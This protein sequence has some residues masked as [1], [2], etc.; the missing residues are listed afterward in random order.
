MSGV[1]HME[2]GPIGK[3]LLLFALPVLISQVL[4]ELYNI[5]DCAI[6]GHFAGGLCLAA[7][8]IAGLLLSVF[9]NFFIGFSSGVSVV[10]GRLF[11]EYDYSSLKK[12]MNSVM[13]LTLLTG[14]IVT[15]LTSAF[16]E[17]LLMLLNCPAEVFAAASLYLHICA[18]GLCA[19][20][21][22]N[23]GTAILRSLADTRAPLLCFFTSCISNLALDILFVV[24]FDM[25]IAGA[26]AATLISQWILAILIFV[27]LKSLG[28]EC[29]LELKGDHL[30]LK[31]L[32]DILKIG[33]PA[34]MQALFM[35]MS[36]LILQTNINTFGPAAVAGMTCYSKLEGCLYLPAFSYGIAL[37]GFVGQN[38][39]A[40]RTDRIQ[41]AVRISNRLMWAVILPLSLLMVFASPLLLKIFTND[42]D[43]L[44]NAHEALAWNSP[45][46]VIYAMN[47]V[48]LGALKGSGR[49][50]YP[51]IC[52]L[53]CYSIFRVLWCNMLI[54]FFNTM[55]VV[56]LCYDIS[57]FLMFFMLLP[58][59]KST[60]G[61]KGK[62]QPVYPTA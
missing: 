40:G 38:Y 20:L 10:T 55:T 7:T 59:Y 25:G 52:T 12:T 27:R 36:S 58:V 56:Y 19:Q 17:S 49:T 50:F 6:I 48:Y 9:I 11:G 1:V 60:Y 43:I 21:I 41:E 39:G 23:V 8:G 62:R 31:E 13:R 18:L 54:P 15:I 14:I 61:I 53:T 30:T 57:Y 3:A 26:A 33:M 32:L 51:M 42:P 46:Y 28:G 16:T 24:V 45:F 2:K 5:T 37:T 44:F 35:S 47:Q 4:Q 22:Y 34:G 29:S